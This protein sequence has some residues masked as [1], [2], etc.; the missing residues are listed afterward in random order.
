MT[1]QLEQGSED[2]ASR[3]FKQL[4]R[5]LDGGLVD[6]VA[7][8]GGILRGFSARLGPYET[9]ITLRAEFPGGAMVAFV[10]SSSLIEA[11]LKADRDA[12]GDKL[13]WR[14]DQY[15]G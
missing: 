10:G 14:P 1:R 11:L 7:R 13:R 8:A 9:L 3:R 2:R 15:G 6:A 5:S 12:R 4:G